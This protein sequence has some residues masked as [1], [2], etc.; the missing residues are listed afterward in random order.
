MTGITA[1]L[2]NIGL[3]LESCTWATGAVVFFLGSCIGSFLNVCIYRLPRGIS[4]VRPGSY[5]P[6]CK[7]PIVWYDNIPL[8]SY[9]LLWKRCRSCRRK[10]SFRY[11]LVELLAGSIFLS[12]FVYYGLSSFFFFYGYF[13]SALLVVAFVDFEHQVIPDEVSLTG[14]LFGLL[15]CFVF[16]GVLDEVNPRLALADSTLGVLAGGAMIYATGTIGRFVFRREAM[17]GGDIKLMA[18]IGAFLG[19]RLVIITYFVAPILAAPIGIILKL[20]KKADVIPYGPFLALASLIVILFG[21]QIIQLV[22]GIH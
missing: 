15:F 7:T 1:Y 10:I 17:G 4:V 19:L 16:P 3:F 13:I 11:Y 6:H 12:L 5:C 2:N 18:M 22:L 9:V 8:V 20:T 14:I 21:N